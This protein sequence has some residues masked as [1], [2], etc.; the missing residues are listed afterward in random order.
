MTS[1]R[2]RPVSMD[3]HPHTPRNRILL[4]RQRQVLIFQNVF[5]HLFIFRTL[6]F[7]QT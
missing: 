2:Y 6:T 3:N 5:E 1:Q 7:F 4:N